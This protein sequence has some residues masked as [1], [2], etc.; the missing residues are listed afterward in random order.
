MEKENKEKLAYISLQEASKSCNYSQEY[1]SLRARQGKL[2]SAKF[3]RNWVTTREWLTEYIEKSEEYNNTHNGNGHNKIKYLEDIKSLSQIPA[4]PISGILEFKKI[5]IIKVPYNLP[6]DPEFSFNFKPAAA[7][8]LFLFLT[9]GFFSRQT[10][11]N[12]TIESAS[13]LIHE[14]SLSIETQKANVESEMLTAD[15]QEKL[16]AYFKDLAYGIRL[17]FSSL[18]EQ[19]M[20][21]FDS[22]SKK[23]AGENKNEGMVVVSSS[24]ENEAIK[25]KIQKS[26]SDDVKV[27]PKDDGSGIITPV[28]QEGDGDEYFYIMV[29]IKN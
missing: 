29:P 5:K 1:L 22:S 16:G 7:L 4:I 15:L 6:V 21:W 17:K 3:G 9:V 19:V 2:K 11:I 10:L 23:N 27:D 8:V 20:S 14:I 13:S 12:K 26:F 28:F 25:A 24:E 18:K